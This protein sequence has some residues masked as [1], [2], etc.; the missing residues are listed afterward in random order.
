MLI[1]GHIFLVFV[2]LLI[3]AL[4]LWIFITTS[5][6]RWFAKAIVTTGLLLALASA[7]IGL[8]A[9]YGFPY[10]EHPNNESYYLVGSYIVEPN[11]KSGHKGNIF[12][13]LI[14]KKE[15]GEKMDWLDKLGLVV[16]TEQPR[17]W[18][19]P[20][21]REM[22]R[23]L[24][25][26]DKQRQGGTIAVKIGKKKKKGQSHSGDN[27]EERQKFIPYILPEGFKPSKEYNMGT[28]PQ[29]PAP[30]NE[31]ANS[32]YGVSDGWLGDYD[33]EASTNE[34]NSNTSDGTPDMQVDIGIASPDG[35]PSTN[36]NTQ[37]Q[38]LPTDRGGHPDIN[39]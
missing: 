18:V 36:N 25:G 3:G 1:Q 19:I 38:Q 28:Q 32:E 2:L 4:T 26:L 5:N 10:N 13:W 34:Q 7:W 22:H 16:N 39:P 30:L 29:D 31:P 17:A 15:A 14:P 35:T 6:A 8:R 11:P 24:K 23:Q 21:T 37:E 33:E 12:L 20:Y 27:M 9:I